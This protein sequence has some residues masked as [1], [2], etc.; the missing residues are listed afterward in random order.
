MFEEIKVKESYYERLIERLKPDI[1][2]TDSILYSLVLA[3][4]GFG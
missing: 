1:I 3:F 2:I 4:H